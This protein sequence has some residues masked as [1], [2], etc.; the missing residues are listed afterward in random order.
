MHSRSG[1]AKMS[2]VAQTNTADLIPVVGLRLLEGRVGSTL[3]MQLLAS[4]P[5]VVCDRRYPIG[6]YRYL[7]YCVRVAQQM[8]TP[9]DPERDVGV[10]EMLFGPTDRTGPLPWPAEV[11]SVETLGPRALR[12]LWEACS[13][14]FRERDPSSRWY[15]EKLACPV[16]PIVAAEIPLRVVNVVRDP[17]DVV[18]SMIA[19]SDRSVAWGFGRAPGVTD[20][21]W[22]TGLVRTFATRIDMMLVPSA[23][24][25]LLRYEDF[26]V[27]LH[28]TADL[29]GETLGVQL[30]AD[31]A[32]AQRP[33]NHVTTTSAAESIGRWR[34]DLAPDLADA[35][36][37]TLGPR[38]E[39][40]GYTRG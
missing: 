11:L 23:G 3:L 37:S 10:T 40:L 17:R 35:I 30:D 22:I 31:A 8:G 25:T 13:A 21:E 33:Q 1:T 9:F 15:T 34:R 32:L 28:T 7:S 4:A 29:L 18:A 16:E 24:S 20:D 6:E 12:A 26:A 5:E 27:N 39:A 36:W 19:F 38:L 2:A 14:G